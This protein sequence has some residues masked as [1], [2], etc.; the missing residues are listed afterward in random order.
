MDGGY[1]L[2][3][4]DIR[5]RSLML[6]KLAHLGFVRMALNLTN[7]LQPLSTVLFLIGK[8]NVA[9]GEVGT[10]FQSTAMILGRVL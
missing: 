6:T 9:Y 10:F 8:G 7:S 5:R 1:W 4:V 2:L 3:V